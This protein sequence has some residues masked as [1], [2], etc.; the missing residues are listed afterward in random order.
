[1]VLCMSEVGT[2]GYIRWRDLDAHEQR[3]RVEIK[4]CSNSLGEG[5]RNLE[6]RIDAM[7]STMDQLR[8]AKSLITVLIGSNVLLAA[9]TGILILD[10]F[11]H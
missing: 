8:G 2:N 11:L 6:S 1:M 4:E 9:A 7:E 10:F 3:M 5:V